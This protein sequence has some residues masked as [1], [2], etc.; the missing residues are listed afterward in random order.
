MEPRKATDVLID[1]ERKIDALLSIIQAQDLNIKILS[2][3][4]SILID[5]INTK[6]IN[7][8]PAII[9]GT[10]RTA[11][12]KNIQIKSENNLPI[13]NNPVGFRRTSRP[14]TYAGDDQ[15]L[16]QPKLIQKTIEHQIDTNQSDEFVDYDSNQQQ[17]QKNK[18]GRPK[19]VEQTNIMNT[20]QITESKIS[21][22]EPVLGTIPVSQRI[23]DKNGKSLFLADV[24]IYELISNE[25]LYKTRTNGMGRWM[26]TLNPGKYKIVIKKMQSL[27]KEKIDVSQ[28]I[29]VLND[30]SSQE[31]NVFIVK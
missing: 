19:K 21:Q 7:Q 13:T 12:Q 18:R 28:E 17:E 15:F 24:E 31:F 3:K 4:L 14:E 6:K 1:I 29:T 25:F 22:S 20:P 9:S 8:P 16:T 5:D 11:D 23:V 26:A 30:N 27:S 2:N 10:I